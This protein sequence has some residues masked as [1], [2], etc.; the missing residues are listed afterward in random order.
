MS[1]TPPH[2]I[3]MLGDE[4]GY[5]NVGW[6]SNITLSPNLND[7][8]SGGVTLERHYVQRWCAATRTALLTGRYPYNAG[9][10]EYNQRGVEEERS[11]VPLSFHMLPKILKE[12][13]PIPY[14]THML[15]KW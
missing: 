1:A 3:F 12:Y 10:N 7:L 13:A 9:L 14:R 8:A 6:H 2:I 11:A 5:N 4:V 15:G